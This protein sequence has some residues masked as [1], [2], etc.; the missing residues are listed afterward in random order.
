MNV[1]LIMMT[2][3]CHS[4]ISEILDSIFAHV[5]YIDEVTGGAEKDKLFEKF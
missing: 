2:K 4:I 5:T 1:T 3:L